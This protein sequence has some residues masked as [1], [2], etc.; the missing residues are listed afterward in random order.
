VPVCPNDANFVYETPL[1][2]FEYAD[3]RF[4]D[5]ELIE[6]GGGRFVVTKIAASPLPQDER[7]CAYLQ[8]R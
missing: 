5:G 3:Y 4:V 2:D 7:P 1:Q 8:E 6:D